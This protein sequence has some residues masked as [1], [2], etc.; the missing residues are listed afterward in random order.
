MKNNRKH[1]PNSSSLHM[2][3]D[4]LMVA[5]TAVI[6]FFMT[7]C[8]KNDNGTTR[9]IVKDEAIATPIGNILDGL[10]PNDDEPGFIFAITRGDSLVYEYSR[11]IADMSKEEAITDSTLFN[12]SSGSKLFTSIAIMKLV[13]EGAL[14]L[15]DTLDKYFDELPTDIFSKITIRD[16]L[17]HTSGLPDIRPRTNEE[18]G[19]YITN[20]NSVFGDI[21]TYRRYGRC[22][23]HMKIFSLLRKTENEP[24]KI[25]RRHDPSYLLVTPLIER[26]TGCV[27]EDWM[28]ENIFDP[29]DVHNIFY[30][31][32]GKRYPHIAHG[33][34]KPTTEEKQPLVWRSK[35]GKWEEADYG[36]I[37]FFLTRA[38]RGVFA[39]SNEFLKFLNA[40]YRGDI[41]PD[42]TVRKLDVPYFDSDDKY[43]FFGLGNALHIEEGLPVKRYH[44]YNNGGFQAIEA[45]FPG[46]DIN[47][48]LL[49]NRNDWNYR[50][51]AARID[52]VLKAEK[53]FERAQQ[54]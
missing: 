12:L 40:L 28:Q 35:D 31:E 4:R 27:F 10:F 18:W 3:C 54:E 39:S 52:S 7:A 49:T 36:E 1:N 29:A 6:I 19:E 13:D 44:M 46:Y 45:S 22:N 37:D 33:Y 23:E 25:Y 38:D 42:S 24:G 53:W 47:Y 5:V 41:I 50:K 48:V 51:T 17:T 16:I 32:V 2:M 43:V 15:D 14:S 21:Q 8:D 9:R 30:Y 11:G 26:V 20:H 34:A